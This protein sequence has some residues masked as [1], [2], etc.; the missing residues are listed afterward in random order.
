M[1]VQWDAAQR[2]RS[3]YAHWVEADYEIVDGVLRVVED[4][5][6]EGGGYL[7]MTTPAIV[8]DF[9]RL[10]IG[11]EAGLCAFARRWGLLGYER[12]TRL[13]SPSGFPVPLRRDPVAWVWGHLGGLQTALR[14]WKFW[15]EQDIDGYRRYLDRRRFPRAARRAGPIN[16]LHRVGRFA[17]AQRVV[18]E[19]FAD[20]SGREASVGELLIVAGDNAQI[21][22]LVLRGDDEEVRS[23]EGA[24]VFI[25]H[26]INPNLSGVHAEISPFFDSRPEEPFVATGWDSLMSV[27]YRHLFEIMASGQVEECRECGTPFVRTDGRQRFCPPTPPA[28]ES[29]CAMRFHKREQRKRTAEA[30]ASDGT[31]EAN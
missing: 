19:Y 25:R 9:V 5:G 29:Q 7:P 18:Q 12:L 13:K 10:R 20:V 11:D 14:I 1:P 16:R 15:R 21:E 4:S 3:L 30:M 2:R 17:E 27:I 31:T 23:W 22:G 28:R 24:W 8:G 26:I 6:E